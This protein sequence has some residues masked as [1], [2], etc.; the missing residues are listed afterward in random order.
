MIG[1]VAS[2]VAAAV[3]KSWIPLLTAIA[4][5]LALRWRKAALF[6]VSLYLLAVIYSPGFDS[7]YTARGLRELV[8]LSTT[9]VLILNDVLQGKIKAEDKRDLALMGVLAV[10]AVSDYTLFAALIGVTVYELRESFGKAAFY[11][12]FWLAVTGAILLILRGKLPGAAA[13]AFVMSALGLAAVAV[14]MIRD[15]DHAGV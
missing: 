15:T 6:G 7:V 5:V 2:I 1:L 14:G 11:F 8:L 10:S 12:L 13:E 9:T 4:Y 3:L